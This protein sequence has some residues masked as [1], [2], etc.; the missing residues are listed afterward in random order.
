MV[1]VLAF[2]ALCAV[3]RLQKRRV[4]NVEFSFLGPLDTGTCFTAR[5]SLIDCAALRL[6]PVSDQFQKKKRRK[7]MKTN[8]KNEGAIDKTNEKLRL[9]VASFAASAQK[10]HFMK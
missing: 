8:V 4:S 5:P 3:I 10:V 6:A 2:H 7:N 9:F 1:A